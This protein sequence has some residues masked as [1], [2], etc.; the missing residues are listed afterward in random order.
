MYLSHYNLDAKPFQISPDPKFL[1]KGEKHTEALASMKYG[2]SNNHGFLLLTGDA[3]TGKTTLINQLINDLE[4]NVVVSTV[5]D[6]KLSTIEFLN[7]ISQNFRIK[8]SFRTKLEFLRYFN[9][10]LCHMYKIWIL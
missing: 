2:V 9:G 3:G 4:Q 8:R 6:P 10:F 1:W 5:R 7:Y